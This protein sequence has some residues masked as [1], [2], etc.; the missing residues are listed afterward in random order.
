MHDGKNLGRVGTLERDN[1]TTESGNT[2]RRMPGPDP[3]KGAGQ[4]ASARADCEATASHQ[5]RVGNTL[6]RLKTRRATASEHHS[7]QWL[8]RYGFPRGE[9]LEATYSSTR[10]AS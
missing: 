6:G 8:E 7:K 2:L 4:E 1:A 5:A 3:E 9:A 10:E